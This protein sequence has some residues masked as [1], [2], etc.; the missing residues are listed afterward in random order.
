[1][2]GSN[3][4]GSEKVDG[5]HNIMKDVYKVDLSKDE[6]QKIINEHYLSKP[7]SGQK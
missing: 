3:L 4:I 2:Q 6:I 5:I 7:S 1:M